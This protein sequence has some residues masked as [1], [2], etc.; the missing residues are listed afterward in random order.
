MVNLIECMLRLDPTKA[1]TAL[2]CLKHPYFDEMLNIFGEALDMGANRTFIE[3]LERTWKAVHM[4]DDHLQPIT[5]PVCRTKK[6]K[7]TRGY[8]ITSGGAQKDLI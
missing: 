2:Q 7:I 6:K 4:Y 8:K 1:P 5:S 3:H